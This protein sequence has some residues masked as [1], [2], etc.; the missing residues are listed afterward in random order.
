MKILPKKLEEKI[1]TRSDENA[2]RRLDTPQDLL[3][4][5]SNDYLGF[6]RSERIFNRAVTI[7]EKNN[8]IQNG[9]TGS[10]LLSGNSTLH[11]EAEKKIATF[12]QADSALIF[13]SGYDAN[14]GFFSCVPQRGD[15][16][17]Y[18]E[19]SHASIRDG[20]RLGMAK[21]FKFKHND[22]EDLKSKIQHSLSKKPTEIYVV[23]ESVFSMDGDSPNLE[24]FAGF[25]NEN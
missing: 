24:A 20:I 5:S 12:H 16:V 13:N 4:F 1:T 9:A 6:A 15:M 11:E 21:A 3:Y 25:C 17:F 8:F 14:L 22:L 18:D 10:R 2:L 23:T 19:F 7:L